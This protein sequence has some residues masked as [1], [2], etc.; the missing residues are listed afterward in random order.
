MQIKR[1][2]TLSGTMAFAM[3]VAAAAASAAVDNWK[4]LDEGLYMREFESPQKSDMGSSKITVLRINPANYQFKLLTISELG[5]KAMTAKEWAKKYNLTAAINAGM[6]QADS[7]TSVGY[8]KNFSHVNNPKLAKSYRAAMVFNPVDSSVAEAQL[9]DSDCQNMDDIR[10][11]YNTLIQIIRMVSCTNKNVWAQG[12]A[13][14]SIA[15]IAMDKS[16]NILFLFSRSP[17]SV[18]DFIEI[19][20]SL[21]I[22]I[23]TAA[24]LEGGRQA[25]FYVTAKDN[26][27]EKIGGYGTNYDDDNAF[28]SAWPIPN[29]IG[30][31]KKRTPAAMPATPPATAPAAVKETK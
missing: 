18:H 27:V 22:S 30:I 10:A 13:A 9:I 20:M 26:E 11:K 7:A 3:F 2:W 23:S 31:V 19:I 24:Y 8:M 25:S 29:V 14:W 28:Q 16:G 6:Y 15:A 4:R 5:T 21:P 17:Y 1:L 12:Q